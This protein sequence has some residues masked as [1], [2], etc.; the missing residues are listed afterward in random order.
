MFTSHIV[1][2]KLLSG[3]WPQRKTIESIC[4]KMLESA[5]I[6]KLEIPLLP[7]S[8]VDN[9]GCSDVGSEQLLFIFDSTTSR[10]KV[11]KL[12]TTRPTSPKFVSSITSLQ[13]TH[14]EGEEAGQPVEKD[15]A[16][17]TVQPKQ[18]SDNEK[19]S[20]VVIHDG[21]HVTPL[22]VSVNNFSPANNHLLPLVV[23]EPIAI[24]NSHQQS[25]LQQPDNL[26]LTNFSPRIERLDVTTTVTE[27][28][29]PEQVQIDEHHHQAGGQ[30]RKGSD[31]LAETKLLIE[32]SL[33]PDDTE[34]GVRKKN[35]EHQ[36]EEAEGKGEGQ[37]DYKWEDDDGENDEGKESDEGGESPKFLIK[38]VLNSLGSMYF[39]LIVITSC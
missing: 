27:Q 29:Q 15:E 17:V 18:I 5:G 1:H 7:L 19:L 22:A 37:H 2:S 24:Y 35:D 26:I 39:E 14:K 32:S 28:Q 12:P 23:E 31:I 13:S 8:Y 4:I 11:Q 3:A 25:Q 21:D 10:K 6:A 30:A 38:D 33:S 34:I 9:I 16:V 20:Q 36:K